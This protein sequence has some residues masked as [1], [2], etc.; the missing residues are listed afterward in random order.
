MSGS[1]FARTSAVVG[2]NKFCCSRKNYQQDMNGNSISPER[3]HLRTRWFREMWAIGWLEAL[4][5][6]TD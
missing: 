1:Q 3:G 2:L 4:V 5:I 6:M